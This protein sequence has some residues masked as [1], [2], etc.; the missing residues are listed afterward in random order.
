MGKTGVEMRYHKK[1]D[2][3]LFYH[4]QREELK[5]LSA[6]NQT[7][8]RGKNRNNNNNTTYRNGHNDNKR[9]KTEAKV[10]QK[11]IASA[12][13]AGLASNKAPSGKVEVSDVEA[14]SITAAVTDAMN[15]HNKKNIPPD[16]S[17]VQVVDPEAGVPT[18]D[19]AVKSK[20]GGQNLNR[21]LNKA[22]K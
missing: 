16:V 22:K 10:Q 1:A 13:A 3:V 18:A 9:R 17:A 12:A 19:P 8:N 21:I 15:A 7:Q 20:Y 5:Q 2:F 11:M 4:K 6:T 14:A